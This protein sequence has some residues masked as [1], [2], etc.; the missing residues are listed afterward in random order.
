MEISNPLTDAIE[1]V[2][3]TGINFKNA[4]VNIRSAFSIT[5]PKVLEC[6]ELAKSYKF[7]N[8]I[9]LSTCNRTEIYGIGSEKLAEEIIL[10]VTGQDPEVFSQYKFT[11]HSEEAL[12]HIFYVASGLDSQIL[13]DYEILGQFR[14]ACKTAKAHLLLGPVFERMANTC[15]QASKEIKTKTALSKGTVS[16]SYAAIEVIKE[17]FESQTI[18]VLL[19]GTGKLGNNIAKNIRHYL[20]EVRLSVTNRTRARTQELVNMYGFDEIAFDALNEKAKDFE[21]IIICANISQLLP[22]YF[23]HANTRLMLD[24]SIPESVHPD[25]YKRNT[26]EVLNIDDISRILER[27]IDQRKAYLP[28]AKNIISRHVAAF[29]DWLKLYKQ[30]ENIIV[31]KEM[32]GKESQQCPYLLSLDDTTREQKVHNALQAFVKKLKQNPDLVFEPE[33]VIASFKA[34]NHSQIESNN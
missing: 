1:N 33:Q 20:P 8:F 30:R 10:K 14:G 22:E 31:V 11:K 4:N 29:T 23:A 7:S 16:A 9:V 34:L 17:R 12:E 25:L 26:P 18:N 27:S 13:G 24:L 15:I 5:T 3:V 19:I 6:Y 21:V 32:L 2:F 28:V